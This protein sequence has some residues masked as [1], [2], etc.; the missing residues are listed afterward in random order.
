MQVEVNKQISVAQ[1]VDVVLQLVDEHGGQFN[2]IN[3]A[4]SVNTLAKL[5]G[6]EAKRA[7]S[8]VQV[9]DTLTKDERFARLIEMVS[10]HCGKLGGRGVANVLNGLAVL[11][12]NLGVQAVDEKLAIQLVNT[13]KRTAGDM[14]AQGVANTLNALSRLDVIAGAMSPAGWDAVVRAAERTA[15]TMNAQGAANTLNALRNLD[16]AA[17]AMSPAG[18]DAVAKAVER[19][20]TLLAGWDIVANAQGIA[21]TLNA[22]S[23]LDAAASAMSPAGWDAVVEAAERTAPTMNAQNAPDTLD[24]VA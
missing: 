8:P 18:W 5:A 3:V 14:N 11:Q 12:A 19:T 1:S 24:N 10:V 13:L 22:L 15:P 4:T 23:K 17:S 21:N 7:G 16:A 2:F 20:A 6:L 9:R